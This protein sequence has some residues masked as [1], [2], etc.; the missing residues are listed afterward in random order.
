MKVENKKI[1]NICLI[2]VLVAL[3]KYS[4]SVNSNSTADIAKPVF[5]VDGE[6]NIKIDGIEDTEYTF[7]IKNYT[8][9]DI[10]DVDMDYTIEI[11]NNSEANLDFEL[12]RNG[13]AIS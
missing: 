6:Q 4:R 9:Q 5:I 7:S 13:T 8:F 3:S 1:L 2:V 12:L 11:V 10:S